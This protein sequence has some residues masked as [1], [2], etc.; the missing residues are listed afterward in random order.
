MRRNV[1]ATGDRFYSSG[2]PL[3]VHHKAH[4]DGGML[5]VAT[6]SAVQLFA[7][8]PH[9]M[10]WAADKTATRPRW[11]RNRGQVRIGFR[12]IVEKAERLR[13]LRQDEQRSGRDPVSHPELESYAAFLAHCDLAHVRPVVA[14]ERGPFTLYNAVRRC[15]G[16][17]DL[18][19]DQTDR[20][21]LAGGGAIAYALSEV[22]FFVEERR[23]RQLEYARRLLRMKRRAM[24]VALG[25]PA[26]HA[27]FAVRLLA[28]MPRSSVSLATLRG[29]RTLLHAGDHRILKL[30][31]HCDR[32]TTQVLELVSDPMLLPAL[33]PHL[34][35]D[36]G[37]LPRTDDTDDRTAE[38]LRDALDLV[39]LRGG[40]VP[41][42]RSLEA[43]RALHESE[44]TR[45][46][47]ERGSV[48]TNDLRPAPLAEIPGVIEYVSHSSSALHA[49][50][51]TMH[52]C[53]AG[54]GRR[55]KNGECFVYRVLTPERCTLSI[56]RGEN[57]EFA[58]CEL[59]AAWN[60]QP[61]RTTREAVETWLRD[62]RPLS[63]DELPANYASQL[64]PAEPPRAPGP[65]YVNPLYAE[66]LF[67]KPHY[68][69]PDCEPGYL[70][71]I[72]QAAW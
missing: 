19:G 29:V 42:I 11:R 68:G 41:R 66:P 59:K 15:P 57:G 44:V 25:F 63:A 10:P 12:V 34:L 5:F 61:T 52:N 18:L 40:A 71:S 8:Y 4:R 58:I 60:K 53:V 14:Y 16:L 21:G 6:A 37:R 23:P 38:T 27:R 72:A 35:D 13:A 48:A 26:H 62:A 32:V 67:V 28:K 7:T 31:A 70:E 50:G 30:L 1:S 54:Y 49:E 3:R 20:D 65:H 36:V 51:A 22:G 33:T 17:L 45:Q 55:V 64:E 24:L 47:R 39:A 69:H 56:T 46:A 2:H 43:L 9:A